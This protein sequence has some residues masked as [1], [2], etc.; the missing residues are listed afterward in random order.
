MLINEMSKEVSFK[1][2]NWPFGIDLSTTARL[3]VSNNGS[4]RET[5]FITE[6][7]SEIP[8]EHL[9]TK[10][11]FVEFHEESMLP[12]YF[13]AEIISEPFKNQVVYLKIQ[14]PPS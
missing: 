6:M 4:C 7:I 11:F 5:F 13:E 9:L 12:E 3:I 2:K 14:E 1:I 10:E 8:A